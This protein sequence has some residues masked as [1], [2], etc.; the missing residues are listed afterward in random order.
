VNIFPGRLAVTLA[1]SFFCAAAYS[2]AQ[3]TFGLTNGYVS[4]IDGGSNVAFSLTFNQV[5]DFFALDQSGRQASGFQFYISTST[6][7]RGI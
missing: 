5:P 1:A 6:D 2:D 4:N 7:I 3:V